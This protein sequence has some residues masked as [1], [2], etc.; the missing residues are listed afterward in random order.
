MFMTASADVLVDIDWIYSGSSPDFYIREFS[1]GHQILYGPYRDC[2]DGSS[3]VRAEQALRLNIVRSNLCS[4]LFPVGVSQ[5]V[6]MVSRIIDQSCR[7]QSRST[8]GVTELLIAPALHATSLALGRMRFS[9]R[10]PPGALRRARYSAIIFSDD[11][12]CAAPRHLAAPGRSASGFGRIGVGQQCPVGSGGRSSTPMSCN[13]RAR[14]PNIAA[15]PRGG[16]SG[17][18]TPWPEDVEPVRSVQ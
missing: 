7:H 11:C 12:I 13:T 18:G 6:P 5:L 8:L 2:E 3:L 10:P 16:M 14:A 17:R 9:P 15:S 4:G 1:L